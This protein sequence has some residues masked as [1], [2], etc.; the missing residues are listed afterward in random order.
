MDTGTTRSTSQVS[1]QWYVDV[2][3]SSI[4]EF[5]SNTLYQPS[6]SE[7]KSSYFDRG[8]RFFTQPRSNNAKADLNQHESFSRG[9]LVGGRF[10]SHDPLEESRV[11]R[12]AWLHRR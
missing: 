5:D 6:S 9:M 1:S 7:R 11:K 3:D 10:G 2:A 4:I 12:V 8:T